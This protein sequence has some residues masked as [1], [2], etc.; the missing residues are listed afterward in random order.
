MSF[1]I[2]FLTIVGFLFF[3]S[4][5]DEAVGTPPGAS[6][7]TSVDY[8][9]TVMTVQ[10]EQSTDEDFQDTRYFMLQVKMESKSL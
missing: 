7:V 9:S 6:N 1:I 10:W 3:T 2:K 8:T 5:E 4:C